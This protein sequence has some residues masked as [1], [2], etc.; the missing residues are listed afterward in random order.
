MDITL[1]QLNKAKV[2]LYAGNPVIKHFGL[3]TVAADPS[4]LTPELTPDG[5]WRLYAHSLQGVY[6]FI[7]DDGVKFEFERTLISPSG[8]GWMGN[9]VYASCL[10]QSGK[11]V[12][13]Y[14]NARDIADPLRGREGIGMGKLVFPV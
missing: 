5:K 6:E 7:S 14:F 4:V 3:S 9:Y 8:S 13:I 2:E 11:E 1:S 12:R 10:A